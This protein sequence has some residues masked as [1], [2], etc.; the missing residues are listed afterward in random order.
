MMI[1]PRG[2]YLQATRATYQS[3]LPRL[4]IINNWGPVG[5]PMICVLK[6]PALTLST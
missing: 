1:E 3:E 4:R 2:S 5:S 6:V